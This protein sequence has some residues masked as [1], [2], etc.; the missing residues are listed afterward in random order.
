VPVCALVG[1]QIIPELVEIR[2]EPE[3]KEEGFKAATNLPP[4]D[5][6]ATHAQRGTFVEYVQLVPESVER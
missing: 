1:V 4:S 5:D 2:I 3:G 6:E